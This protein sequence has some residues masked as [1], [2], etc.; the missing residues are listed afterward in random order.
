MPP[1]LPADVDRCQVEDALDEFFAANHDPKQAGWDARDVTA[2][3]EKWS[4]V[5]ESALISASGK[6][7]RH[8]HGGTPQVELKPPEWAHRMPGP[9]EVDDP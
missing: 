1:T 6:T 8:R 9:S 7:Q 4:W 5:F 2:L 3:F